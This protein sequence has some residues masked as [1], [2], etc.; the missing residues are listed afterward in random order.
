MWLVRPTP[1]DLAVTVQIDAPDAPG[2][3]KRSSIRGWS[4]GRQAPGSWRTAG[5]GRLADLVQQSLNARV[6]GS[7]TTSQVGHG[8]VVQQVGLDLGGDGG[9]A[10]HRGCGAELVAAYDVMGPELAGRSP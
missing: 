5:D 6:E 9:G 1:S 8:A 3:R 7:A 4:G 10:V 2:V